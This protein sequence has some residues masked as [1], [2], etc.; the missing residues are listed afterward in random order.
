MMKT[1]LKRASFIGFILAIAPAVS[2]ADSFKVGYNSE[3]YVKN[4]GRYDEHW[5]CG[6]QAQSCHGNRVNGK[7]MPHWQYHGDSFTYNSKTYW[8]CDG[9]STKQGQYIE[10]KDWI[11]REV[12]HIE[13]FPGGTCTWYERYNVCDE[14]DEAASDK[15]CTQPTGH[16]ASGYV[17][18]NGKCVA[19]CASG[20]VFDGDSDNCVPCETNERQA[21]YQGQCKTCEINEILNKKTMNCEKITDIEE[22]ML[23]ISAMAHETCWLCISPA[24]LE[25]CLKYVTTHGVIEQGAEWAN[26]CALNSTSESKPGE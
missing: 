6:N 9:T 25:A 10:R 18:R 11:I 17:S 8:C 14:V 4:D 23:L 13:T 7:D 2:Q 3:C 26:Q 16:C 22:S 5:F 24:A 15:P 21:I 12:P 1:I 19:Q 20:Q